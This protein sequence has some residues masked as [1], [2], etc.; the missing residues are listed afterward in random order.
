MRNLLQTMQT[1]TFSIFSPTFLAVFVF[2]TAPSFIF[3]QDDIVELRFTTA[4]DCQRNIYEATLQMRA[5]SDTFRIGTSSV[6]LTYN[7]AALSFSEYESKNF[8]GS[9]LCVLNAAKAWDSHAFDGSVQGAFNLTLNLN[10]EDWSCPI[11]ENDWID[12]AILSFNITNN[13]LS[14]GLQISEENTSFNRNAP[15]DG[16][17]SPT[18][19]LF[20]GVD[21]SLACS[22][23]DLPQLK[24]DEFFID[25]PALTFS[26]NVLTNDIATNPA[27]SISANPAKGTVNINNNGQFIY[28]A[29]TAFCGTDQFIYK[30]CTDSNSDCCT[31]ATV[32]LH[33][34][35]NSPPSFVSLPQ[36]ITIACGD[37]P[38][39]D[40]LEAVDNCGTVLIIHQQNAVLGNCPIKEVLTRTWI[41]TDACENSSSV[42]QKITIIDEEGPKF[43][44]TPSDMTVSCEQIPPPDNLFVTNNCGE[45][46]EVFFTE[47]SIENECGYTLRRSWKS[48]DVCDNETI[49]DQKIVVIDSVPPI[50][51]CLGEAVIHCADFATF[52]SNSDLPIV[53]DNCDEGAAISVTFRDKTVSDNCQNGLLRQIERTWLAADR[54]GNVAECIQIIK[55]IDELAPILRCPDDLTLDCGQSISPEANES[56]AT[57]F[58]SCT[59][60]NVTFEDDITLPNHCNFDFIDIKRTWS[61]TDAC[62][63][64]TTCTQIITVNGD[65]CPQTI[66]KDEVIYAC[67][68]D[69]IDI[70]D[71]LDILP[72]THYS[73][74]DRNTEEHILDPNHYL[75]QNFG[76]ERGFKEIATE[77]YD[78]AGCLID[79]IYLSIIIIPEIYANVQIT[80]EGCGVALLMECPDLYTIAWTDSDEKQGTGAQYIANPGTSGEVTFVLEYTS[81]SLPDN[82]NLPCL[83]AVLKGTYN[84]PDD[85]L[86]AGTPCNDENPNTINDVEDGACNCEGMTCPEIMELDTI[87]NIC[88]GTEIDLKNYFDLPESIDYEGFDKNNSELSSIYIGKAICGIVQDGGKIS[89]KNADGCTLKNIHVTIITY[90]EIV[91]AIT[92]PDSNSCKAVLTVEC[93]E[94]FRVHWRDDKGNIGE[95]TEYIGVEGTAGFVEF[96][97]TAN[98]AVNFLGDSTNFCQRTIFRANYD[99]PIGCPPGLAEDRILAVCD[100]EELNIVEY[101]QIEADQ[102]FEIEGIDLSASG[103]YIFNNDSCEVLHFVLQ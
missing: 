95:G 20:A 66:I 37:V 34:E 59:T 71:F 26:E 53:S 62:G 36:D 57:A 14:S 8:D 39:M 48:T 16:T 103:N 78:E 97:V 24:A 29:S 96:T 102:R 46:S 64:R 41:A 25:C 73:L 49:I 89:V 91:G 44:S 75:V 76:C 82:L 98:E 58:D 47:I 6:F 22:S 3:S 101:L 56:W 33:M 32:I 11:I 7:G 55:V 5:K 43:T 54:C 85:C 38:Q 18:K 90:P 45:E 80:N 23:C 84:C 42:S 69:T 100:G 51:E 61:A 30:V 21:E 12:I 92:R 15:N 4:L 87:L 63:N 52:D 27:I 2:F 35:D 17:Q 88:S 94:N 74:F 79:I 28:M 31:T 70:I 65:P 10:L 67:V 1:A 50:I 9:G 40:S 86:P 72:S 81:S 13:N 99:C 77:I 19:G 60:V 83:R 93:P 68:G